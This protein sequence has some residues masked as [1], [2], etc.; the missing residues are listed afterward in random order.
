MGSS[1]D[2]DLLRHHGDADAEPGLLDFAVNVRGNGPPR[3]LRQRLAG[4]LERLGRYPS[5]EEDAAARAAVA[6]R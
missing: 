3:W 1:D 2:H 4:A 5:A 6:A